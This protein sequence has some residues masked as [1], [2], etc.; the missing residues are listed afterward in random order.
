[1]NGIVRPGFFPGPRRRDRV[2]R[3]APVG[4]PGCRSRASARYG[5]AILGCCFRCSQAWPSI[6]PPGSWSCRCLRNTGGAAC[7]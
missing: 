1:M 5:C 4:L 2:P 7:R 6:R 3:T